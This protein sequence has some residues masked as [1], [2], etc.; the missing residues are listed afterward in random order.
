M[1]T[2]ILFRI[3][4]LWYIWQALGFVSVYLKISSLTRIFKQVILNSS[5]KPFIFVELINKPVDIRS[6]VSFST[7]LYLQMHFRIYRVT[8]NFLT[9]TAD[10]TTVLIYAVTVYNLITLEFLVWT[11]SLHYIWCHMLKFLRW[12]YIHF[13][14]IAWKKTVIRYTNRCS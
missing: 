5:T 4:Q 1:F 12:R 13:L 9:T 6:V 3:Y 2:F 8:Y 14:W 10:N 7:E 11:S